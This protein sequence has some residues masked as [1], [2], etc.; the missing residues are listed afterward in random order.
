M[1]G[2]NSFCEHI[3][4]STNIVLHQFVILRVVKNF[5]V[6]LR[7]EPEHDT[8]NNM[9]FAPNENSYQHARPTK[10]ISLRCPNEEVLGPRLPSW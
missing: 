8:T 5:M 6:Y 1:A 3:L 7:F 10:L 4:F 9:A 2:Q